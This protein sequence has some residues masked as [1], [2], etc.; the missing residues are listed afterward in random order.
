MKF[1]CCLGRTLEALLLLLLLLSRKLHFVAL[2]KNYRVVGKER[3]NELIQER[4]RNKESLGNGSFAKI[5]LFIGF[6]LKCQND[7][8]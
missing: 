1:I 6:H 5:I 2:V 3:A 7:A 4:A 8:E